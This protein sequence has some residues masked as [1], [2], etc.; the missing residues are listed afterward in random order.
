[1]SPNSYLTLGQFQRLVGNTIRMNRDLQSAWILAELSDV[2]VSGGHC[3]ME[4]VEKDET[5]GMRARMRAMIWRGTLDVLR[6]KMLD[7]TGNDIRSGM[8][9]LVRG[10]ANH[11][12]VYGLS[13]VISDIDPSYTLGDMERIRREILS[14]LVKEGVADRNKMLRVPAA[15]QRIAV[16][17]AGGA[18][19]FGDFTNQLHTNSE[20]F[21]VYP[22]LFEAVMQGDRTVPSVLQAL[23][24]VEDTTDFAKW[25][26]VVIIRGGGSTTDLNS[27]DN[28]ELARRVC[29]Y[30]LP[31][32][33]GIGHERDRTVLDELACVRCKTPTAV[34]AWILES[35]SQTYIR[36][37]ESARTIGR[38][39]AE[40][41][42]GDQMRLRQLENSMPAIVATRTM[43]ARMDL[44]SKTARISRVLDN[45]TTVA[46]SRLHLMAR[47][48]DTAAAGV[49]TRA[50]ASLTRLE[51]M[52]RV[53]SPANTLGRGYSI[54]R[55]NGHAVTDVNDLKEGDRIETAFLDGTV[56]STVESKRK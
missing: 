51:D 48:I 30:P 4:L 43:R 52:H 56:V 8:K 23:D 46:G 26:C 39:A 6:R 53:L 41:I 34:A 29:T 2:R 54:T 38:Y 9:M 36:I 50:R 49:I 45:K 15:P 10:S 40:A 17:S 3:Y 44:Q 27:F 24:N 1:M 28:Y 32:V 18:A 16:I 37:F 19:G 11:H 47:R 20:G 35:L 22:F 25:D 14:R 55:L 33:V 7:A 21:V 5:G 31:V 42:R 12:E 13:F